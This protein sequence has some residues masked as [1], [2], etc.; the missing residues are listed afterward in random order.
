MKEFNVSKYWGELAIKLTKENIE[1]KRQLTIIS[2]EEEMRILSNETDTLIKKNLG[3]KIKWKNIKMKNLMK[4]K[5][6]MNLK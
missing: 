1:L 6:K 2:I 3:G 4:S 5:L